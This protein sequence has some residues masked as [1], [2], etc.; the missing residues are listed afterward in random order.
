MGQM[1]ANSSNVELRI[2]GG[3]AVKETLKRQGFRWN[4]SGK[5]WVKRFPEQAF[6]QKTFLGQAWLKKVEVEIYVN[7]V[8]S[9]SRRREHLKM[10]PEHL[11]RP[12]K[13]V[14]YWRG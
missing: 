9:Y 7:G 5:F 4:A 10:N 14:K 6:S 1:R 11:I 12:G 2:Y 8:R 3:F 13:R